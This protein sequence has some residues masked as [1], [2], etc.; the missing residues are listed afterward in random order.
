MARLRRESLALYSL[1]FWTLA[2]DAQAL[3]TFDSKPALQAA[4]DLWCSD[5]PAALAEYGNIA[6]WNVSRITDMSCLFSA[7]C[8]GSATGKSTCSPDIGSWVTSSVTTMSGMFLG[9][10]SFDKD[11]S[12]W[13]TSSVGKVR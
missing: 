10:S 4:V 8:G 9:A 12:S 6:D 3:G 13:V 2:A 1:G 5:E 11:I 7:W